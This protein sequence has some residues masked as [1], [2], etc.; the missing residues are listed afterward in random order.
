MHEVALLVI[1]SM[2][3]SA[4]LGHVAHVLGTPEKLAWYLQVRQWKAQ[5]FFLALFIAG[6]GL[7][8]I[9]TG[10]GYWF[11]FKLSSGAALSLMLGTGLAALGY[12]WSFADMTT[13]VEPHLTALKYVG[14]VVLVILTTYSKVYSDAAIAELAGLPPQALPAS[15]LFLTFWLTPCL[16]LVVLA[17]AVGYLAIPGTFLMLG[18]GIYLD[19]RKDKSSSSKAKRASER[20]IAAFVA[21]SF[22]SVLLLTLV[23]GMLG[24]NFYEKRLRKAIAYSS[25]HL[26]A[27]Y[28]GLPDSEGAAITMLTDNRAGLAIPDKAQGYTFSIILCKPKLKSPEEVTALLP[29]NKP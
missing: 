16:G 21:M 1:F 13:K 19:I 4:V 28:C 27:S 29:G 8:F 11:D 3:F 9:A 22:F 17:L 24:K 26:P 15:Q 23:Q 6:V 2:V 18:V 5:E 12:L 20:Y 14:G 7:M 10:A 25:F